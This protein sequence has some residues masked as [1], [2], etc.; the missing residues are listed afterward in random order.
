MQMCV[1][2]VVSLT[3]VEDLLVVGER[4][5]LSVMIL[6]GDAL[7]EL[8]HTVAILLHRRRRWKF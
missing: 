5:L 2:I 8:V 6:E 7:F 4:R 3:D 1:A